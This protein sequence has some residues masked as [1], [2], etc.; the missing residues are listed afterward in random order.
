MKDGQIVKIDINARNAID[1]EKDTEGKNWRQT[2]NEKIKNPNLGIPKILMF[3][4]ALGEAIGLIVA[5]PTHLSFVQ[6][7]QPQ[8]AQHAQAASGVAFLQSL[9]VGQRQC[10]QSGV[11][12]PA[13][14]QGD[15]RGRR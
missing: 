5:C 1:I 10:G 7:L 2:V 8:R 11:G 12:C 14:E 15:R 13:S 4:T 3:L 6:L 9:R